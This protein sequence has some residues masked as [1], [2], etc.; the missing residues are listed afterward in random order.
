MLLQQQQQQRW[1]SLSLSSEAWRRGAHPRR[2]GATL[3]AEALVWRE[4]R[5]CGS[6]WC[7]CRRRRRRLFERGEKGLF[8][9]GWRARARGAR[10]LGWRPAFAPSTRTPLLFCVWPSSTVLAASAFLRGGFFFVLL[11]HLPTKQNNSPCILPIICQRA[12]DA[13]P[14]CLSK[15]AL[16]TK[17]CSSFFFGFGFGRRRNKTRV[18]W[19]H[20]AKG[21]TLRRVVHCFPAPAS[22]QGLAHHRAAGKGTVV[23]AGRAGRQSR[24]DQAGGGRRL[25]VAGAAE[26]DAAAARAAQPFAAAAASTTNST[27]AAAQEEEHGARTH[28][29]KGTM[30]LSRECCCSAFAGGVRG[31]TASLEREERAS[32]H[33]H[34]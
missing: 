34:E 26:G 4:S 25:S 20:S 15:K 13:P 16:P 17:R 10:A 12:G 30:H 3:H 22:W 24:A 19:G 14:F 21:A 6:C 8:I 11:L 18:W 23:R 31:E 29:S 1:S 32:T 33:A 2:W 28:K 9:C 7:C 27:A 5:R